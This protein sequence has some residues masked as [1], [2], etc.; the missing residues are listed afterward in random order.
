[1]RDVTSNKI[2]T[3]WIIIGDK[4]HCASKTHAC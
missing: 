3:T 2:F 1:M 4:C